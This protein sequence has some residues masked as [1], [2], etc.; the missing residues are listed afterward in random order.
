ML[1]IFLTLSTWEERCIRNL[2]AWKEKETLR[3]NE[4]SDKNRTSACVYVMYQTVP[5]V[6]THTQTQTHSLTL[7]HTY[8]QTFLLV[9]FGGYLS[10]LQKLCD[11]F[12]PIQTRL[13]V[14]ILCIKGEKKKRR[15]KMKTISFFTLLSIYIFFFLFFI[16]SSSALVCFAFI[17]FRSTPYQ[18]YMSRT[19]N[20]SCTNHFM[21][22]FSFA[23][24]YYWK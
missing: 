1:T 5:I 16:A 18:Y 3:Q 11:W 14:K 20:I 6:P 19:L 22:S 23:A 8:R 7:F 21:R 10:L 2:N 13:N 12:Y 9:S 17:S 15:S 24:S 4:I